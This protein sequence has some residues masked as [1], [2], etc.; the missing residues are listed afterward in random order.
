MAK[1]REL[2]AVKTTALKE[3]EARCEAATQAAQRQAGFYKRQAAALQRQL[4]EATHRARPPEV[5][6]R[7]AGHRAG[8]SAAEGGAPP[9]PPPTDVAPENG[10][11]ALPPR[12][13]RPVVA[14]DDVRQPGEAA[15]ASTAGPSPAELSPVEPEAG[16]GEARKRRSSGWWDRLHGRHGAA[17]ERRAE[18]VEQGQAKRREREVS[19]PG[20]VCAPCVLAQR[21]GNLRRVR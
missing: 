12:E 16:E 1:D 19:A 13:A 8:A 5:A 4:L 11:A 7:P 2:Q 17:L 3:V 10:G 9:P 21:Q 18:L 20:A 15:Q 14:A 6:P